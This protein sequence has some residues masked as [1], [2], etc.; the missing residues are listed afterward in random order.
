MKAIQFSVVL[1]LLAST[2]FSQVVGVAGECRSWADD[3]HEFY[4]AIS[5]A[6][7]G[8]L[9]ETLAKYQIDTLYCE[10]VCYSDFFDRYSGRN[11]LKKHCY[12]FFRTEIQ[13][14]VVRRDEFHHLEGSPQGRYPKVV[15]F[16]HSFKTME[17]EGFSL[18]AIY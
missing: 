1:F 16:H 8:V 14:G 18:Y 9:N 3:K 6:L 10:E 4:A 5:P 2:C 7:R 17:L 11:V 13:H 12:L 15:L